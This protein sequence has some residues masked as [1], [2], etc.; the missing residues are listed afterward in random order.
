MSDSLF[1]EVTNGT[2]SL[3]IENQLRIRLTED[4]LDS[5]FLYVRNQYNQGDIEFFVSEIENGNFD[6]PCDC[7]MDWVKAHVE[8]LALDLQEAIYDDEQE[9]WWE[10][11]CSVI[12]KRLWKERDAARQGGNGNG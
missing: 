7:S 3:V 5:I 8:E 1:F 2:P 6:N 4:V 10:R 9:R 12:E 11:I